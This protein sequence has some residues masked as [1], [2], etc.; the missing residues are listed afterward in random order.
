MNDH[1]VL[2]FAQQPQVLRCRE[3]GHTEPVQLPMPISELVGLTDAFMARH[4]A[5]RPRRK[6]EVEP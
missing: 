4:R 1:C 2:D 6:L 3:C 5:C